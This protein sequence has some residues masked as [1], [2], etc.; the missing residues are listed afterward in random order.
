MGG[1]YASSRHAALAALAAAAFAPT[2]AAWGGVFDVRDFGAV[3]DGATLDT[4]AVRSAFAAAAAA[5]GGEVVFPAGYTF[6]TGPFNFTSNNAI[7]VAGTVM[8]TNDPRV[9]WPVIPYFQWFGPTAPTQF[10]PCLMGWH[11]SNVTLS[12]G[13][14]INGNGSAWWPCAKDPSVAPCFGVGR[15]PALFMA[16]DGAGLTLRDVT[17]RDA[18]MWNLRPA[19]MDYVH[20]A[21]V[22]IR[23]PSSSDPVNPSHNTGACGWVA[24]WLHGWMRA[25]ADARACRCCRSPAITHARIR[26]PSRLPLRPSPACAD[27]VDPDCC[28]HVLVE[29]CD[30]SVGDGACGAGDERGVG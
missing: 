1:R 8:F 13:G 12:G 7:T 2:A 27:G 20:V 15:P 22:T 11:V 18:P 10:Q 14:V 29:D 3:G 19:F 21:N 5:N 4:A 26:P 30:I 6:L 9:D 28:R 17:I 25:G 16:Y 23:A 24:G